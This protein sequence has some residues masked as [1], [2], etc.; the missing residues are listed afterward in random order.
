VRRTHRAGTY[1]RVFKPRWDDPLDSAFS[2][3]FGGRWN[4]P[5]AFGVLSLNA[6]LAVAAANARLRHRGR[7]IGLFDL[8]PRSRPHLLQVHVP[9]SAVL[10]VVTDWGVNELRLP[11]NFPW[12]VSHELCRP[13][14]SRAY[15]SKAFRGIASRSAAECSPHDWLGEELSWFDSAPPLRENGPRR[16]FAQWYPDAIP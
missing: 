8:Q 10:D 5:G 16:A 3:R 12:N 2:K 4:A 15:E 7:A 6:T 13:I 9:R 1:F 14:G 11:A